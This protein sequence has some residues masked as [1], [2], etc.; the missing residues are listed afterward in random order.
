VKKE[1]PSRA[2]PI[3]NKA[4]EELEDDD[5]WA[6]LGGVGNRIPGIAPDFDPRTFG[7][8]NLSSVATQSGGF[9]IRKGPDNAVHIRRKTSR[10]R[11]L[12]PK[13]Q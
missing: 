6:H 12:N 9:E 7:C 2:I 10:R 13:V 8:S 3:I 4:M 11:A 5:G 1:P